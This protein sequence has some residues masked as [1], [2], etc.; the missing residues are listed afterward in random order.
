MKRIIFILLFT[1]SLFGQQVDYKVNGGQTDIYNDAIA[2][3][4]DSLH[5]IDNLNID[6][7]FILK[8][9]EFKKNVLPRVIKNIN[10]SFQ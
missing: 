3:Y 1:S 2:H 9:D 6:T 7:L 5:N 8:N 4:I 10:I